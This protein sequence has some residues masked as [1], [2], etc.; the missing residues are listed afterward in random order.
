MINFIESCNIPIDIVMELKRGKLLQNIS[1]YTKDRIYNIIN[2]DET[3]EIIR[4]NLYIGDRKSGLTIPKYS[5][6]LLIINLGHLEN[7]YITTENNNTGVFT[8]LQNQGLYITDIQN[9]GVYITSDTKYIIY[10]ENH[11]QVEYERS[12]NYYRITL[13]A[14]IR[15]KIS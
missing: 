15:N 3:K 1:Q 12:E 9:V 10:N 14:D 11:E 13:T 5:E 7:Y 6:D 4:L 8:L 2:N